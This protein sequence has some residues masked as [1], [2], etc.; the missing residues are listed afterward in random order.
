MVEA[1]IASEWVKWMWIKAALFLCVALWFVY[2]GLIGWPKKNEIVKSYLQF[3][4]EGRSRDWRKH[5]K[6]QGWSIKAP[7]ETYSEEDIYTEGD[8]RGQ[9]IWA[10]VCA[11][12]GAVFLFKLQKERRSVLRADDEAFYLEDGTRLEYEKITSLDIKKWSS[13]GLAYV[14]YEVD[15]NKKKLTVDDLKFEGAGKVLKKVKDNV[16]VVEQI[17]HQTPDPQPNNAENT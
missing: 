9:F 15:G 17:A 11:A 8:I 2:D 10:A 14:R 13:K 4:E 1:K 5:A 3:E 16:K 6:D 7:G 12:V